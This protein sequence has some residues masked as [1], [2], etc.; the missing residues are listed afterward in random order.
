VYSLIPLWYFAGILALVAMFG[1]VALLSKNRRRRF[2]PRILRACLIYTLLFW[3]VIAFT[4]NIERDY[5][6][7]A[8]W[9]HTPGGQPNTA[10]LVTFA[11]PDHP[12]CYERV[13]SPEIYNY[14]AAKNSGVAKLTLRVSYDFG[15]V[16][17]YG[18][19]KVDDR[20]VNQTWVAGNPP[21]QLFNQRSFASRWL[22]L[23]GTGISSLLLRP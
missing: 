23:V 6:L 2:L 3:A 20:P 18:L 10:N 11:Y 12:G 21:W 9:Q 22:K 8:T 15:K 14:L 19:Q 4:T 17:G 5:I 16:R 13:N 7:D 1:V